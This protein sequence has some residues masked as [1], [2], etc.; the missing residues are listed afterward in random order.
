[1]KQCSVLLINAERREATP[2][3][4]LEQAGFRVIEICD[5]PDD[6]VLRAFEVVVVLLPHMQRASMLAARMRAKPHFGHRVL[7]AVVAAP[8]GNDERRDAI[9]S[10]FDDVASD[11]RNSRVLIARILQRLR[12][13]P[14]HR[15]FLPDRRRPAA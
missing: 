3:E 8:V 5:W 4:A 6:G 7:I 14:E 9:R 10:G 15:C 12:A 11:S 1:V 13:R 2:R